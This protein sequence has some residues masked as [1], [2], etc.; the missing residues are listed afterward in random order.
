MN[1][2][3]Q[4]VDMTF[5]RLFKTSFKQ[6]L[7]LGFFTLLLKLP[8]G[9]NIATKIA[10]SGNHDERLALAKLLL[11]KFA[12]IDTAKITKLSCSQLASLS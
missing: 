4:A 6:Y 9:K 3:N 10:V 1:T 7:V 5:K 8:K 2:N 12:M 11:T